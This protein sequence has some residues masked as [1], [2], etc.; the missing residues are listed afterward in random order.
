MAAAAARHGKLDTF[1]ANVFDFFQALPH[2]DGETLGAA[3]DEL[4]SPLCIA[5]V[6]EDYCGS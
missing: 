1:I 2:L 4:F 3:F 6:P 5:P